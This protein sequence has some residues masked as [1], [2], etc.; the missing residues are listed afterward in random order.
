M[1]P[2]SVTSEAP[3]IALSPEPTSMLMAMPSEGVSVTLMVLLPDT[4]SS[5]I[6]LTALLT[7]VENGDVDVP[8]A[9]PEPSLYWRVLS[10]LISVESMVIPSE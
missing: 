5:S 6:A 1:L 7:N 3:E 9:A 2:V 4:P 8:L 10:E